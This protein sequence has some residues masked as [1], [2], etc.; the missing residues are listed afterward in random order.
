MRVR[1]W[2]VGVPLVLVV[3]TVVVTN[4]MG[5]LGTTGCNNKVPSDIMALEAAAERFAALHAGEFPASLADLVR[6]DEHGQTV[7]RGTSLP[8]DPWGRAYRYEPPNT[9]FAFPRIWSYGEDG[10]PGGT[11]DDADFGSWM[12]RW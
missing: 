11:E 5:R 4:V 1:S 7:L 3:A 8:R 10:L 2:L 12:R 6:T 9:E